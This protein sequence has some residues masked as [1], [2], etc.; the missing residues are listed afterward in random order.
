MFFSPT[1]FFFLRSAPPADWQQCGVSTQSCSLPLYSAHS[2]EYFSGL[3][4]G[5]EGGGE[6]LRGSPGIATPKYVTVPPEVLARRS[7]FGILF[8]TTGCCIFGLLIAR[9]G[10]PL[11]AHRGMQLRAKHSP[12]SAGTNNKFAYAPIVRVLLWR[13]IL[14]SWRCYSPSVFWSTEFARLTRLPRCRFATHVNR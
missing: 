11:W 13:G 8:I 2:S 7:A 6:L 10:L 3:G 1:S 4:G 14:H 12:C 9:G 5:R